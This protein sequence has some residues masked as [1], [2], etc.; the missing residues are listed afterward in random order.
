MELKFGEVDLGFM[1][2]KILE[3][4]ILRFEEMGVRIRVNIDEEIFVKIDYEKIIK[5][6]N[7][8]LSDV[9]KYGYLLLDLIIKVEN[10]VGIV[11]I[12]IFNKGKYLEYDKLNVMF[13]S[14]NR[15]DILKLM[16][17]EELEFS[18][19]ILKKVIEFYYGSIW[20]EGYGI[21]RIIYI[22]LLIS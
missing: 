19:G 18:L 3:E 20:V 7:N 4:Y 1:I 17:F 6:F 10:K 5:V 13:E 11:Y 22:K 21:R 14:F 2:I 15:I 12:V 9:E 8:I 16:D